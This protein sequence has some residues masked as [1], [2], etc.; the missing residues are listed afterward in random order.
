MRVRVLGYGVVALSGEA[1]CVRV[2]ILG[3][4]VVA[5]CGSLSRIRDV[6]G[7]YKTGVSGAFA[8]VQ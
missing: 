4:R 6:I 7:C 3:Y 8:M 1:N 5:L 2:R